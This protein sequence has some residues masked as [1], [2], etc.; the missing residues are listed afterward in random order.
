M[1]KIKNVEVVKEI[2]DGM[3]K[4]IVGGLIAAQ[5]SG[6]NSVAEVVNGITPDFQVYSKEDILD[7]FAVFALNVAVSDI[8]REQGITVSAAEEDNSD[9]LPL[10]S[11]GE[12]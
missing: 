7:A 12:A 8:N 3:H 10:A 9:G 1:S 2:L 11:G 4:A 5:L 6:S